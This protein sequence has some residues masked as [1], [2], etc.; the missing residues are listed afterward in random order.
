MSVGRLLADRYR[1]DA[2]IG[3]GGMGTVWRGHDL[4]LDRPVAVKEVRLPA[5]LTDE[6]AAEVTATAVAEGRQSARLIHPHV[7][8]LFDVV[9]STAA[10]ELSSKPGRA[11]GYVT[12]RRV[13]H[14][15]WGVRRFL[16]PASE[17]STFHFGLSTS[18][19]RLFAPWKPI[20]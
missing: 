16:S 18:R 15:R 8:T 20:L 9:L 10:Q 1:L 11:S 12:G 13:S 6:E 14:S 2:V 3:R 17:L 4:R 19:R 7:V 5:R